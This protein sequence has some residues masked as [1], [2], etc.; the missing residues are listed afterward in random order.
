LRQE[1]QF[2]LR[3]ARELPSGE[4]PSLLGEIEEVRY[5]AIA[6][7]STHSPSTSSEPDQLLVIKEAARRLNV[8]ENYLYRHKNKYPFTRREGRKV[9]FSSSGI[10]QYIKQPNGLTAK[11]HRATLK[12]L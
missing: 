2:L 5:T 6:R 9:L 8:S 12:L 7:L 4:L 1:L 10:D 11:K 3:I